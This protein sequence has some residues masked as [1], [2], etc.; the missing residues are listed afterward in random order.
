MH[1]GANTSLLLSDI[2]SDSGAWEKVVGLE[3]GA[4]SM[5]EIWPC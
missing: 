3:A 4:Q 2:A 1:S 5:D